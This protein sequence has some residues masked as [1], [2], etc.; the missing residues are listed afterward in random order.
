M[1]LRSILDIDEND[2]LIK[3]VSDLAFKHGLFDMAEFV[4]QMKEAHK[5]D[6]KTMFQTIDAPTIRKAIKLLLIFT[7]THYAM[8]KHEEFGIIMPSTIEERNVEY[9]TRMYTPIIHKL[10]GD[11]Y[12]EMV[13]ELI[14]VHLPK[15]DDFEPAE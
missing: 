1:I 14:E 9:F 11:Q 15:Y 8:W 5:V 3:E 10:S 12:L 2:P 7:I 6:P 13:K 4:F